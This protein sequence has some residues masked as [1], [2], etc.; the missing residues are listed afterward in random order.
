MTPSQAHQ[1]NDRDTHIATGI[2]DALPTKQARGD[3]PIKSDTP[4]GN[5]GGTP[6]RANLWQFGAYSV[7]LC[8]RPFEELLR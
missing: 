7:P 4:S 8:H 1:M 6:P 3:S 2:W 5:E